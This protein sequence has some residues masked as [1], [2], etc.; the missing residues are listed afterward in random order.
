MDR[1]QAESFNRRLVALERIAN[2]VWPRV[3]DSLP[4]GPSGWEIWAVAIEKRAIA[5][6]DIL[7]VF[8]KESEA[9]KYAER[10]RNRYSHGLQIIRLTL[11]RPEAGRYVTRAY[12]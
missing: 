8:T 3:K 5:E 1:G 10:E 9:E 11:D 6:W 12:D 4:V 7:G 2:G